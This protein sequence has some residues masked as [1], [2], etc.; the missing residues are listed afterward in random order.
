[1]IGRAAAKLTLASLLLTAPVHAQLRGG[2]TSFG[3]SAGAS[4]SE[5][6]GGTINTD[7][8]WGA[9]VGGYASFRP[10]RNTVTALELNWVQKGGGDLQLGYIEIPFPVRTS[11]PPSPNIE[12]GS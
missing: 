9:M 6:R 8:R 1:M 2:T 11:A 12:R 10:S 7:F 3:L 4:S 5:M